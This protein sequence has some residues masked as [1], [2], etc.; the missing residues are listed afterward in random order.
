MTINLMNTYIDITK[1]QINE[2]LKMTIGK[3]YKKQYVDR[4]VDKYINIR[5]Y[6]FY[7]NDS[8]HAIRKNVLEALKNLEEDLIITNINDRYTIQTINMF[9]TFVLHLDNVVYYKDISKIAER[10]IELRK[11]RLNIYEPEWEM[12]FVSKM[13]EWID[14]KATLISC[15]ENPHF[16][17]KIVNY[18]DHI[19]VY[20]VKLKHNIKFPKVY[21]EFAINKGFKSGLVDEDKLTVE[22]YMVVSQI[23]KDVLK[24]NFKRQYVIEFA[25]SILTKPRKEK[26]LL[27]IISNSAIQE[28]IS[29]K[30]KYSEYKQNKEKIHELLRNG[31]QFAVV[32][33]S[34]FSGTYKEIENLQI[35]KY[36]IVKIGTKQHEKITKENM[37]LSNII[38]I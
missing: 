22:Y 26:S 34:S 29:L 17:L 27:N 10:I 21:S 6:N 16:A 32:L 25:P 7:T 24:Q 35:F 37:E 11:E 2:Y 38:E 15:T 4:F 8:N 3:E 30:V 1:K 19:S 20:K 13:Q 23:I 33:D 9:F 31:Y 28:R 14:K 18:P 36:V 5:Y 12:L